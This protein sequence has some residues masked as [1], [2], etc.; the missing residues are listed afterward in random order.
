MG[1]IL[2]YDSIRHMYL[3]PFATLF[4]FL[5]YVAAIIFIGFYS[6]WTFSAAIHLLYEYKTEVT[7][8]IN[9]LIQIFGKSKFIAQ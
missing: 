9:K 3:I 4:M 6:I 2:N 5:S 8:T 7:R 1:S